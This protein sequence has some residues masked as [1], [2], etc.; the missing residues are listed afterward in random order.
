MTGGKEP[1][2]V[3]AMQSLGFNASDA[4]VYVALLKT[5]PATGY[6]LATRS[7]VPRSA[8]YNVLHRLEDTGLVN[9]VQKKPAKFVPLPP[10][11]LLELMQSRFRQDLSRLE[12]SLE[13]LESPSRESITWT[14]RG[15][16]AVIAQAESLIREAQHSVHASIWRREGESLQ[17]PLE[18]AVQRGVGVLLFSFTDLGDLPGRLASYGIDETELEGHWSHRI[19][20]VADHKRLLVGGAENSEETRAVVTEESTLV[21][22]AINNLILDLTLLSQRTG[23]DLS[24]VIRGL[25]EYVAP[26]EALI[27][28]AAKTET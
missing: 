2:I 14:I 8:I 18:K 5:S 7:G 19:I 10:D 3:Q 15:R 11:R 25:T 17:K 28:K 27:E 4:R 24:E 22:M 1:D 13:R 9:A 20:L 12:T 6:E 23:D 26:V 21:E 16:E